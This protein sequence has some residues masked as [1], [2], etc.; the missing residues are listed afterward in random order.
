MSTIVGIDLGTTFSEIA[1]YIDGKATIIEHNGEM[2]LPSYVALSENS[3]LLVGTPA[4]NQYILYP[5]RTIKSIKRKMG[6]TEKVV[7][8]DI[9]YSPPEISA[10]I[11]R[12]LKKRA[13]TFLKRKVEKAVITV[14]AYFTDAQ[15][16]ATRTAG[17]LAGLEVVRIIN[18][19][20]AAAL[21]YETDLKK[22]LKF[23]VYDLGGGTFDASLIQIQMD[24]I[25]V[26]S[27]HGNNRLGGDDFDV[28]LLNHVVK[29][30]HDQYSI[31][32]NS[33]KKAIAR[34]TKAVEEAKK[35]LSFK[36]FAKIEEEAITEKKGKPVNLSIEVSRYEYEDM[37]RPL[38][39][40]TIRAMKITLS[41]AGISAKEIDG[42]ILVGGSTRTP[43]VSELIEKEF[44]IMPRRDV[45]PELSVALG[46]SIQAAMIEGKEVSRVLVDITPYTF[47][48]S[49]IGELDGR[50]SPNKYVPLI[51][52]NTPLPCSM[53]EVFYTLLDNQEEAEVKV[54]QGENM[55][56]MK[57]IFIDKFMVE[58]LSRVPAGNEIIFHVDL[59]ING[60][61]NVK[62]EEKRTGLSKK[63]TIKNAFDSG[64]VIDMDLARKKL[65]ALSGFADEIKYPVNGGT[66]EEISPDSLIYKEI[67]SIIEKA[68]KMLGQ[69]PPDDQE[70][71]INAIE[72]IE[73]HKES[74]NEKDM[75]DSLE[76]LKEL[77]FYLE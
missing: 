46:A 23:I 30:F 56:A 16:H 1:V 54:F 49:V 9:E 20:T 32:L 61:L 22:N 45:N 28:L 51:K 63:L 74:G 33:D 65:N 2:I 72:E 36:P 48:T 7:L 77:L 13:E 57:N 19:P 43:L 53:S 14:P 71:V 10:L 42:I 37:I 15:K 66:E 35:T 59:D 60:I 55:D 41:D 21:A 44:N 34:L 76:E 70:E 58:N 26:L 29:N 52:R 40:E 31:D 3:E 73:E 62:A 8:G 11:L 4:C 75:K 38:I 50:M 47:G 67:E 17:E 12:E 24:V 6:S 64:N 39:E 25:E 5:E 69:I 18:E 27:S 68:R